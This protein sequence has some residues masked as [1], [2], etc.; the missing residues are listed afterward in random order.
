MLRGKAPYEILFGQTLSYK[1]IRV[2]GFL[3]YAHNQRCGGDKFAN[4]RMKYVF[5]GYL[6]KKKGWNLHDMDSGEFFVSKDVVF[7]EN[8]FPY[9]N[10]GTSDH[11]KT[12]T[13]EFDG[14]V[15]KEK[16]M[17]GAGIHGHGAPF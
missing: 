7:M 1:N 13:N 16:M 6:Y 2:F 5:V 9:L 10:K 4:R 8:E 3:A 11:D 17:W 12:R 14:L 15:A